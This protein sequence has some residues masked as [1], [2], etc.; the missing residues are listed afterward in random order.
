[1]TYSSEVTIE[2]QLNNARLA[3]SVNDFNASFDFLSTALDCSDR[4]DADL[5][6][7]DE[8]YSQTKA[9]QL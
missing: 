4:T 7:I 6:L 3:V 5:S 1:M 9:A 8:A 2:A